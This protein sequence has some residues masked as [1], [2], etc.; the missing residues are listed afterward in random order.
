MA[1][2]RKR[3]DD[4]FDFFIEGC[5]GILEIAW[6]AGKQI[7]GLLGYAFV[8]IYRRITGGAQP[9]K[10]LT[11][12]KDSWRS[13]PITG[14]RSAVRKQATPQVWSLQLIQA[15]EW[16]RFEEVV[17]DYYGQ[18]GYRTN[19]TR[20]GADGGVDVML[21]GSTGPKPISIV[22]CKSWSKKVGVKPVRELLGVM[23]ANQ[24]EHGVFVTTSEYT[25]E[26]KDFA[27]G[28]NMQLVDGQMLLGM[29]QELPP[30]KRTAVLKRATAGDYST[31]TCPNCNVK[32]VS[33]ESKKGPSTGS[34]FWGCRNYPRCKQTFKQ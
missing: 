7:G 12:A 14:K 25:Q 16:K 2:K 6:W 15:L 1:R 23:A 17:C 9:T 3:D 24:V 28:V 33:R 29:L 13:L 21:Y 10:P 22:Q 26:A 5:V 31:P 34:F 8:S 30:D 19:T 4:L 20:M 32:M 18:L 11:A 27:L